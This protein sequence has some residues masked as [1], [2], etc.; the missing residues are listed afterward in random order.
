MPPFPNA[1][2]LNAPPSWRCIDF[3]SDLHLH[4][5]LPE[6]TQALAD[7]L[8]STT[9]DAVLMLGDIFEVWVGDDMRGEAYEAACTALLAETGRRLY[10][11]MM[12]G[13]RDF[14]LGH[15]MIAA[16]HAH[17]LQDPTVLVAFGQRILLIHGDELCLSDTAYLKFR[18]Q[19]RNPAW[20]QTFLAAPLKARLD[21]AR[22]M[23]DASQMH[24]QAQASTGWADVDEAAA[25][26][27][28]QAAHAHA[29][30]HGHTHHPADQAFGPEGCLRHVLSDWDL[31]HAHPRAQVLRLSPQGIE[32]ID[33]A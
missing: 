21:Q 29:L 2:T 23:R 25:S 30:I 32:R 9:A 1:G 18:S 31:D 27:W 4:E 15:D 33:L 8:R 11:G 6:T 16:C 10:L 28:M 12:V 5:G 14:L 26:A 7:Y 13:N 22:Q 17:T 3:I 24:Q 19:V 20:Q